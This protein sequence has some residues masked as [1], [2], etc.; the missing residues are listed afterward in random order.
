MNALPFSVLLARP[1]PWVNGRYGRLGPPAA[2][3]AGNG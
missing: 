1:L 2:P 3:Y